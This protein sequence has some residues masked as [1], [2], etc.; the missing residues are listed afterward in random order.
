MNN[1]QNYIVDQVRKQGEVKVEE[2]AD[3]YGVSVE[4]IRR[5]LNTLAKHN[6]LCRTHGGAVS[7]QST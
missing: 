2:L 3:K 6:L 4:T 1:R 7:L 5:D